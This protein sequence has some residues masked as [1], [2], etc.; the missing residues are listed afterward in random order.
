[1]HAYDIDVIMYEKIPFKMYYDFKLLLI[2][3]LFL[4][5]NHT[6]GLVILEMWK[7]Q[8]MHKLSA[9]IAFPNITLNENPLKGKDLEYISGERDKGCV[10][11][12]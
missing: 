10:L 5:L 1:M 11:L 7:L 8:S 3:S 2:K 6:Y 4:V 9:S 12:L